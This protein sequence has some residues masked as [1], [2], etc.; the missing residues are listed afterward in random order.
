MISLCSPISISQHE[1]DSMCTIGFVSLWSVEV[2]CGENDDT[3]C[4]S[5]QCLIFSLCFC[6]LPFSFRGHLLLSCRTRRFRRIIYE[7]V[8]FR[9]CTIIRKR[10]VFSSAHRFVFFLCAIGFAI[11]S[12]ATTNQSCALSIVRIGSRRR[13]CFRNWDNRVSYICVPVGDFDFC[14]RY[15]FGCTAFFRRKFHTGSRG[16]HIFYGI[17]QLLFLFELFA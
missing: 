3:C 16:S 4:D 12:T 15:F 9:N 1:I 14:F 17:F 13:T 5:N 8:H 7:V 11:L 10:K 2:P 6:R